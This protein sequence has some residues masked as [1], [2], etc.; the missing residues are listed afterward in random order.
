MGRSIV[1]EGECCTACPPGGCACG[2]PALR[3]EASYGGISILVTWLAHIGRAEFPEILDL[4][5]RLDH[6][7]LTPDG[8]SLEVFELRRPLQRLGLL[9]SVL[10]LVRYLLDHVA[11]RREHAEQVSVGINV[12]PGLISN[13]S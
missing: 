2:E 10:P 1:P 3:C 5:L 8:Q 9:L 4:L 12:D 6:F 7:E 13:L 11:G